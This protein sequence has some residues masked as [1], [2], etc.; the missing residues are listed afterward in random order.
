MERCK[1]ISLWRYMFL[2]SSSGVPKSIIVRY[3]VAFFFCLLV[4][5]TKNDIVDS[6][7]V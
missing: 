2:L 4:D 5:S 6:D 1:R 3:N 7:V